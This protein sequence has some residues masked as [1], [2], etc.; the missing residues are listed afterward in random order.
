VIVFGQ[1]FKNYRRSPN[2]W[3]AYFQGKSNVL[4]WEKI[5]WATFGAIFS[6]THL[7]TLTPGYICS[8]IE[9]T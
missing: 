7:V 8:I 1:I 2:S 3:S 6:K 4:I 5:G 9:C